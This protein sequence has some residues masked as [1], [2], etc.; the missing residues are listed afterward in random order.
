LVNKWLVAR[1]MQDSWKYD[2]LIEEH[3]GGSTIS[4]V[5]IFGV[6]M[7]FDAHIPSPGLLRH[8]KDLIDSPCLEN[9]GS[10]FASDS[11]Y[12]HWQWEQSARVCQLLNALV[13]MFRRSGHSHGDHCQHIERIEAMNATNHR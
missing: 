12:N 7:P 3:V 11:D 13:R 2:A 8:P 1:E 4:N 9:L 5:A 6:L 10:I